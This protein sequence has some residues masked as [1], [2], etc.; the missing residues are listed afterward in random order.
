MLK[1]SVGLPGKG[2]GQ[3]CGPFSLGLWNPS[4]ALAP[5]AQM[6]FQVPFL[7]ATSISTTRTLTCVG[8]FGSMF[9]AELVFLGAASLRSLN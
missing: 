3:I 9:R 1:G 2:T 8:I 5:G 6:T 4:P 7:I